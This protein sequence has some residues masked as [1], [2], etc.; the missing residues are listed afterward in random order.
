MKIMSLFSGNF[1]VQDRESDTLAPRFGWGKGNGVFFFGWWF[2]G[3]RFWRRDIYNRFGCRIVLGMCGKY[4]CRFLFSK[5]RKC[6]LAEGAKIFKS[7]FSPWII[8]IILR[9]GFPNRHHH[10]VDFLYFF[11]V[12]E[13][14]LNDHYSVIK[15]KAKRERPRLFLRYIVKKCAYLPRQLMLLIGGDI[16]HLVL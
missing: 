3:H 8:P 9:R 11:R 16:R 13:L 7:C 6:P 5:E 15:V 1:R 4:P 10:L 12:V 2:F 14:W